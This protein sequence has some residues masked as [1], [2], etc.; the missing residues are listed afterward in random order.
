MI[1]RLKTK[2]DDANAENVDLLNSKFPDLLHKLK[3][4]YE[5][6]NLVLF[7]SK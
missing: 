4:K 5:G 3:E 2:A 6:A 7:D 1:L